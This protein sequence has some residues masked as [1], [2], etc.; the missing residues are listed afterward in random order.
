MVYLYLISGFILL[1]LGSE[2]L[3]NGSVSISKYFK[4]PAIIVGLTAIAFGTSAPELAINVNASLKDSAAITFG[5]IMGS[6][7]A[8]ILFVMGIAALI[9]PIKVV[10]SCKKTELYFLLV[11][12]G[13][14]YVMCF[15]TAILRF[16]GFLLLML[17]FSY[18]FIM[19]RGIMLT[20]KI[21]E[22]QEEK[23]E[24]ESERVNI[25]NAILLVITGS[26]LLA[27]GGNLFTEG[28]I[29]VS[30]IWGISEAL[31]AVTVVAL[32]SSTP[33]LMTTIIASIKRQHGIA[34]G[35]IVGSNLFN[36]LGVLGISA[37]IRPVEIEPSFLTID[38]HFLLFATLM[39]YFV[40]RFFKSVNRYVGFML[41]SLYIIYIIMQLQFT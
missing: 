24:E 9:Y 13:I 33:E 10:K 4:I 23:I 12:N 31:I 1:F 5:N 27:Y 18:F 11:G 28:A 41:F 22:K 17:L 30:K 8:N 25:V 21:T 40:L 3:I 37:L 15:R 16:E 38:I 26:F 7:M 39:L 36:V 29:L 20:L 6:N 19:I 14:L 34:I 35:G 32:G 2:A